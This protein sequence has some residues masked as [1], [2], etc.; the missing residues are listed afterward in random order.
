MA[1]A[2]GMLGFQRFVVLKRLILVYAEAIGVIIVHAIC[3]S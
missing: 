3:F 1:P 2:W